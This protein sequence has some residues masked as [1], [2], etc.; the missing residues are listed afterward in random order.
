VFKLSLAKILL[1]F[2]ALLVV[3]GLYALTVVDLN[4]EQLTKKAEMIVIG[5]VL[6][7][8]YERDA[9]LKRQ[10]TYVH[11]QVTETIK[12]KNVARELTL[13]IPGGVSSEF[14]VEIPGAPDYFRSEE[15]LLFLERRTDNSLFPISF[16]LGKYS[17]Y[18]D[19]ET[20]RKMVARSIEGTGKYF[21][22]P[23]E[24]PAQRLES[25]K[26]VFLDDFKQKIRQIAERR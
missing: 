1:G 15:V 26:K 6:S 23:R 7:A 8:H 24:M 21:A 9:K 19:S 13:K 25:D 17:I 10:Y 11:V 12:G 22:E 18:R 5:K 20:G 4:D 16:S 2:T 14:R 3:P